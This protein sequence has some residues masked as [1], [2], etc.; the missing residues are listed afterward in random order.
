[1]E[2]RALPPPPPPGAAAAVAS[3]ADGRALF[4]A[5]IAA[6]TIRVQDDSFAASEVLS[7]N[8]SQSHLAQTQL[9]DMCP[10]LGESHPFE[11]FERLKARKPRLC[12]AID[13]VLD[14]CLP[15]RGKPNYVPPAMRRRLAANF[16]LM[17]AGQLKGVCREVADLFLAEESLVEMRA[18]VKVFGDLHG[19]CSDL[20]QFFQCFGTPSH[21]SGDINYCSY[22][23]IGDFVDRGAHS[24]ETATLL[25]CLKLRYHP[26]VVILRGNH[27]DAAINKVFFFRLHV[28]S[29]VSPPLPT[30]SSP[31]VFSHLLLRSPHLFLRLFS[32]PSL[33]SP[34]PL[35][36]SKT[37]GF[38]R[39]CLGSAA[40]SRHRRGEE[41]AE[42]ETY[43]GRLENGIGFAPKVCGYFEDAFDALPF[44]ALIEGRVLAVHGGIGQSVRRLEQIRA[45]ERPVKPLG[46]H[47]DDPVVVDLLWSDPTESCHLAEHAD[48]AINL[49]RGK[50]MKFFGPDDVERFCI[51]NN[52][53]LIVRAH[54]CVAEGWEMWN[55]KRTMTLFSAPNYCGCHGNAGA[56]LEINRDLQI[57]PKILLPHEAHEAGAWTDRAPSPVAAGEL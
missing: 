2:T 6:Q 24:L 18:P 11:Y 1:M 42:A 10:S 32:S 53:D 37:Y 38:M 45:I 14:R 9:S 49:K 21:T 41:A 25:F 22:L 28:P 31:I 43:P 27:E 30:S 47:L 26:H 8:P 54:Q 15:R 46:G 40:P 5:S 34:S 7:S 51:A 20:L 16:D 52:V 13:G 50:H 29:S 48:A 17:T 39:E 19:Q 56:M 23:F 55:S 4:H 35:L 36:S 12:A 3:A 44:G 57:F 33:F